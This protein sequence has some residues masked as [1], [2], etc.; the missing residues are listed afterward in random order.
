MS[1]FSE[2]H[3]INKDY[4]YRSGP[5]EFFKDFIEGVQPG[6]ILLP[7]E[8]YGHN[9]IFAAARGWE[10]NTFDFS[11]NARRKAM[12]LWYKEGINPDYFVADI[13]FHELE[14]EM[15]DVIALIHVHFQ[16]HNRSYIHKKLVSSLKSG[17][18]FLIEAYAREK[19]AGKSVCHAGK[20]I[21][22]DLKDLQSDFSCL[23]IETLYKA[24]NKVLRRETGLRPVNV[25][26]MIAL[27]Q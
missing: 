6:R 17:G 12:E 5:D 23:E 27:K 8:G 14:E 13:E 25:I 15:Y 11:L 26:R 24:E 21:L 2:S 4:T 3:N 19:S 1:E 20:D 7:A 10:V 22:Y 18:F 9:A 16:S